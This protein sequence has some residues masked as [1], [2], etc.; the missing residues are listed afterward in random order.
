MSVG[1]LNQLGKISKYV[2][3]IAIIIM[4][5]TIYFARMPLFFMALGLF[6]M[7]LVLSMTMSV[8]KP[9]IMDKV[10]DIEALEKQGLTIVNCPHCNKK[11]VLEDIYCIY[12]HSPLSD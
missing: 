11:N 7:G 12:C 9:F 2:M 5:I 1:K 4:A 6:I 8:L 10:L 3:G